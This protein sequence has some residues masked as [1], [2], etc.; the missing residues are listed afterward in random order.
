M[1]PL[2][3]VLRTESQDLNERRAPRRT[4]RLDVSNDPHSQDSVR[5]LIRNLSER[6]LLVETNAQLTAG[7]LITVNLPQVGATSSRVVWNDG[8][9][10]GCEFLS[11]VTK[12]AVSAA[13]LRAPVEFGQPQTALPQLPV[14][15]PFGYGPD[16]SAVPHSDGP[17]IRIVAIICLITMSFIALLFIYS[18]AGLQISG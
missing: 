3:A 4:L 1:L 10:Y 15:A 17:V 6:G 7:E 18:L 5:V 11:P 9:F 16:V 2:A 14:G 13:L 8:D 12:A